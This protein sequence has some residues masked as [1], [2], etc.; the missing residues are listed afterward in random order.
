MMDRQ[1]S[2]PIMTAVMLPAPLMSTALGVDWSTTK[3]ELHHRI[4][5]DHGR[6]S[7]GPMDLYTVRGTIS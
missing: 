7:G 5:I 3:R 6:R 4:R 2:V 1:G